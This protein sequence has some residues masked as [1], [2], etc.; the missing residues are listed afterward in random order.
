VII[1]LWQEEMDPHNFQCVSCTI[2]RQNHSPKHISVVQSDQ[3]DFTVLTIT[4]LPD[5]LHPS[6]YNL[7][8]YDQAILSYK[9][10]HDKNEKGDINICKS[11]RHELIDQ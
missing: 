7:E 2:C 10:L 4:Y 5:I 9:G 11:C 3:I 6:A 1:Q 8:A